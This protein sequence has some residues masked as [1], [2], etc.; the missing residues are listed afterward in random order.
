MTSLILFYFVFLLWAWIYQL[1]CF[2]VRAHLIEYLQFVELIRFFATILQNLTFL[3]LADV[4][5][6]HIFARLY[7]S[8]LFIFLLRDLEPNV[9]S[10]PR[11]IL[12][13]AALG[14]LVSSSQRGILT[15]KSSETC[16]YCQSLHI[17]VSHFTFLSVISHSCQYNM[18]YHLY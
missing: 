7:R 11:D 16:H 6:H 17:L 15:F 10:L 4:A 13:T 8:Y 18:S 5:M 14:I 2:L 3:F 9:D 1:N 12:T